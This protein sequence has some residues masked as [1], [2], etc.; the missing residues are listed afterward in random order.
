MYRMII[1][2]DE[3]LVLNNL[4][5]FIHRELPEIHV[6]AIFSASSEALEYLKNHRIDIVL[7]D[8]SMPEP[9][10]I[11]IAEFCYKMT[12]G[13]LVIFLSAYRKF[14]YAHSAI[15]Y[16]VFDY[17]LKPLSKNQLLSSLSSA[18]DKLK[19]RADAPVLT[20]FAEDRYVL[21]CQEVFS[22]L[23]CSCITDEATLYK[24]LASIG[25]S[26]R[27]ADRPAITFNLLLTDLSAHAANE[28]ERGALFHHLLHWICQNTDDVFFAPIWY[29]KNRIEIIGVGKKSDL[30]TADIL[31][32][33][34]QLVQNDLT[35]RFKIDS[36][37]TVTNEFPSMKSLLSVRSNPDADADSKKRFL[38]Y[39][40]QNY[41]EHLTLEVA[42]R[43]FNL[44]RVYFS[45]YY[46]KCTGEN[47]STTLNRVRINKAK[48]LLKNPN[49][50]ITNVMHEVGYK[51]STHFYKTF[52]NLV[53]CS[54]AE[55]QKSIADK[56]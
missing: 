34:E 4:T 48:E 30:S 37:V 25:L 45:V 7:T 12:P 16:H 24:K 51:H 47:F 35:E 21:L 5:G 28:Q 2:D 26:D 1:V 44:S 14:E 50:K 33:F 43:H 38:E 36:A 17:I 40:E 54:P 22:D 11:D 3:T 15:D 9:T 46:K 20:D 10:G 41:K 49:V 29:T 13:T 18:V 32:Y 8:I 56:Q 55:Y 31:S 52:K 42:S 39:I 53:G 27:A 6:E 23:I 19:T